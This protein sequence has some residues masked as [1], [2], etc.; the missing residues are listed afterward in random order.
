MLNQA[1]FLVTVSIILFHSAAMYCCLSSPKRHPILIPSAADRQYTYHYNLLNLRMLAFLFFVISLPFIIIQNI[2]FI[3]LISQGGYLALFQQDVK[4]G[5]ENWQSILCTFFLPGVLFFLASAPKRAP[6]VMVSI[7][8]ISVYTC[9]C[10]FV[11]GRGAASTVVLAFL[12]L[13][14]NSVKRIKPVLVVCLCIGAMIIFPAIQAVRN[15][16]RNQS[17]SEYINVLFEQE[18]QWYDT[19]AEMGN[20]FGTIIGTINLVPNLVPYSYGHGYCNAA[21][22]VFPNVFGIEREKTYSIWYIET[23]D[24]LQYANGGGLGFSVIAEAYANFSWCGPPIVLG[25]L[26]FF[27][28][29]FVRQTRQNPSPFKFALEAVLLTGILVLPR[30]EIG[31]CLRPFVWYC[32]IP[33]FLLQRRSSFESASCGDQICPIT[34]LILPNEAQTKQ[35]A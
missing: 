3:S 15:M 17:L 7:V 5:I 26:G 10:L 28:A 8:L 35:V 2:D 27:L 34:K 16:E 32:L 9:V 4:H 25:L 33:Y 31:V 12:L 21:L 6:T 13:Y 18:T 19:I 11:G 29:K 20:S 23:V 30:S 1:V 24:P 22:R 14:H